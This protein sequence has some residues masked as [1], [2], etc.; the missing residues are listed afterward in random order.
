M[1]GC[2]QFWPDLRPVVRAQVAAG[3]GATGGAFDG[4]A[5]VDRDG[6]VA[7]EPVR[8]VGCVA[9]DLGR[10]ARLGATAL[11][12]E[13]VGE[14]HARHFSESQKHVYSVSRIYL[15]SLALS[16]ATMKDID[17]IRRENLRAIELEFGG[18]AGTAKRLGMSNAQFTNLR[19]GAKDSKTGKPRG[20]R[21][22]TARKIEVAAGKPIGWLDRNN[23]F[24]TQPAA[25][26]EPGPD[27]RGKVPLISWVQAGAWCHASEPLGA[28]DVERWM[29]C[30][31]AHSDQTFVLR[32]RGDSMVAAHG[33]TYPEG[34]FIFVDGAQ[35]LPP[36]GALVIA[37]LEN[38]NDT[39]FKVYKNEDGR[40]WLMPLNP[41]HPS[42]HEPFHILG[43]VI[44][45]WEDA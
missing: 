23:T 18:P 19:D 41:Q 35:K 10:K 38:S 34:C 29:D 22:E 1:L 3:D 32:V 36:S 12:F 26:T 42:I 20:M 8:H 11:R 9:A 5:A 44:G 4:G 31:S 24:T 15:F 21:K 37:C 6:A 30:P 13:V 33:K 28:Y 2:G 7:S 27:T 25:N 45:K 40:Q 14:F 16:N 39:T 17:E 43:T